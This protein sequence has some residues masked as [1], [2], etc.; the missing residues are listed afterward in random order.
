L[1]S[2]NVPVTGYEPSETWI[3]NPCIEGITAVAR[4]S[5][6]IPLI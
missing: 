5:L 3:K 4:P 6:E 2:P 1:L